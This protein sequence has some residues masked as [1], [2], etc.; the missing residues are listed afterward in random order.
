M[1]FFS[2]VVSRGSDRWSHPLQDFDRC[3][4]LLG[5]GDK[6]NDGLGFRGLGADIERERDGELGAN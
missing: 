6:G 2:S 5:A 4:P 1:S 3:G